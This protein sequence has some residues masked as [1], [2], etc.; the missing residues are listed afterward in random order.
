MIQIEQLEEMFESI[1]A[2]GSCDLEQPCL[3]SYFFTDSD[4][5][6]LIAVAPELERLGYTV[7]GLLEPSPEDDDQETIYLRFDRVERHTVSSLNQ[8]N[9]ELYAFA[10]KHGLA[11]YDGMEVGPAQPGI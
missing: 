2:N 3:W 8:R 4:R 11:S 10:A 6:R 9:H 1:R 7:A 5:E